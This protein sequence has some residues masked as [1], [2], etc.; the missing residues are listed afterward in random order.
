M[1]RFD[2][3]LQLPLQARVVLVALIALVAI[4]LF[5]VGFWVIDEAVSQLQFSEQT[6]P[7]IGRLLGYIEHEKPLRLAQNQTREQLAALS[8]SSESDANQVGAQLQ[9]ALRGYAEESGLTVSG[10]QLLK[11][12]NTEAFE[13]FELMT[14]ELNM[15][16]EPDA[17]DGFLALVDAHQPVLRIDQLA[18]AQQRQTRRSSRRANADELDARDVIMQVTISALRVA[19]P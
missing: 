12:T 9:Q 19:T 4:P 17:V 2:F 5:G 14:V 16:G 15:T 1:T 7:R 18:L 13:G 3:L 8:Y 6:K 10:S 11:S